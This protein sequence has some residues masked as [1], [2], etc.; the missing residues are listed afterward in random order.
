MIGT[1]VPFKGVRRVT[2]PRKAE[3]TGKGWGR[4]WGKRVSVLIC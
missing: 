4:R 2:W 3:A 1:L